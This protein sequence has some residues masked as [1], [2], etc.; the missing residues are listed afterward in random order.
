MH[1]LDPLAYGRLSEMSPGFFGRS[2]LMPDPVVP[3]LQASRQEARRRLGVPEDGRY[4]GSVGASDGRKG[5]DRLIR[6]FATAPLRPD[7][8]LLLVGPVAAPVA[9]MLRTEFASLVRQRRIIAIDRYVT[10]E[11]LDAGVLAMDLVCTPYPRHIGSASIVIR[12]AVADRPVLASNFGWMGFVVPRFSLGVTCDVG[13]SVRFPDVL[14][15]AL[16]DAERF[17]PAPAARRFV[18]YH[19][20]ENFAACWTQRLRERMGLPSAEQTVAWEWALG[21]EDNSTGVTAATAC[22]VGDAAGECRQ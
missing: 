18:R 14:A 16:D 11:E 13:D 17:Q 3:P 2:R 12:A 22:P 21:E 1:H 20:V 8:R 4:V 7:D 6:A 5:I 9:G 10:D 19:S 15:S